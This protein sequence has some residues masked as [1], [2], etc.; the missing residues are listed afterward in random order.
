MSG[1]ALAYAAF[2]ARGT[3]KTLWVKELLRKTKP[4]RL[5]VWDFKHDPS[6]REGAGVA[7]TNLADLARG[8][9]AARFALR[10]LVDHNRETI[11]QFDLFC[12]IAWAAGDLTM[13]VDELPEVTK[14]N[15]APPAWRKCVNVGRE[16]QDAGKIKRL[17]I[18]GAGQRPA[19]CDKTFIANCDVIHTG[20]L[21][22]MGDAKRIASAWGVRPE[23]LATLPDLA[24]VEKRADTAAVSRG[25][26][27]LPG[28]LPKIYKKRSPL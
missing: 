25:V 17:T 21:G 13:F 9:A 26:L 28:A 6:L 15:R 7:V 5:L 20:R 10:Y 3:G 16:Y 23:E 4:A 24:W 14:S 8:A 22:D 18:I 2:G 19:E 12:R 1:K 11:S 27:R